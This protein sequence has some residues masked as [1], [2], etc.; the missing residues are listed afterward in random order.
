MN[1]KLKK[2]DVLMEAIWL[3]IIFLIPLFFTT[4]I[5]GVWQ[6][7]KS[8][9]FQSL[10][11]LLVFLWAGKLVFN[12]SFFQKDKKERNKILKKNF[13]FIFPVFLYLLILGLAVLFSKSFHNSFWGYYYRKMGYLI[14]LFFFFFFLVLFF[15]LKNKKQIQRIFYTILASCFFVILY[16]FVQFLGVDPFSWSEPYL[17]SQRIFSSFGQPN[18]LA[19]WLLLIAPIFIWLFWFYS[20]KRERKGSFL[21]IFLRPLIFCFFV[22]SLITLFL[23]KSRGAWIGLG[24]SFL[25][26]LIGFFCLKKKKKIAYGI[27]GF[28]I[29][30]LVLVFLLNLNPLLV[31]KNDPVL[32]KRIKSFSHLKEAGQL[33]FIFW[34]DGLD[35]IKKRPFLGYGLE[36]QKNIYAP[37]YRPEY[38]ALEAINLMP[39][40]AHN[41]FIDTTLNAGLIGLLSYLFLLGWVFFFGLKK[42]FN[43]KEGFNFEERIMTLVLLIGLLGYLI[44]L[45]FSFHVV[46]TAVY[47]WAYLAVILKIVYGVENK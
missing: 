32:I 21:K 46:S 13:K 42:V 25:L 5:N 41:D 39:D 38:A 10:T 24:L 35:L 40:R 31:N 1:N 43:K 19:S 4:T 9:L 44:S 6:I 28:L 12:S 2:I 33:R 45:Q 3:A 22:L 27:T 14:Y 8:I 37:Y 20:Q 29:I 34:Q 7:S 36:S 26:G 18:F 11:T 15:N 47:F 30:I 16:G 23:T 17:V